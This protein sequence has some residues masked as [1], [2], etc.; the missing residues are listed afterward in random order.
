MSRVKWILG[1]VGLLSAC[2]LPGCKRT[3][4]EGFS[5]GSGDVSRLLFE[6]LHQYGGS[7]VPLTEVR[8]FVVKRYEFKEDAHG[9]QVFCEGDNVGTLLS[10]FEPHFGSPAI[11]NSNQNSVHA[12]DYSNR[13][14]GSMIRC[15]SS[16]DRSGSKSPI[17]THVSLLR[18][19]ALQKRAE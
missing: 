19:A 15:L 17:W 1:C 4:G 2:L 9:L 7:N 6:K 3:R 10:V 16:S 5:V 11:V 14:C 18:P 13:Q 8:P 12:F